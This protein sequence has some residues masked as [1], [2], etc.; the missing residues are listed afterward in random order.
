MITIPWDPDLV[1][2]SVRVSWHSLF[3]FI[4]LIVGSALSIRLSRYF[5]RD[6][7][8]YPFA[9]A[10]ILGGLASARIAHVIDNWSI[11]QGDYLKIVS[12]AGGGIG[13]MGAPIGS[14]VAGYV[15]A[16]VLRLPLGFMFDI[17]VVGIALGEAIGRIG[18][19][20]NGEHHGTP[21]AE[22]LGICVTY[23]SPATLGQST[24]VHFIGLYDS[25]LMLAT[26]VVLLAAWRKVR[27]RYPEGRIWAGYLILLGAGRF[28]ESFLR[29]DPVVAFGLQE[30]QILG[31]AYLV[32]GAVYLAWSSR[33]SVDALRPPEK[34]SNSR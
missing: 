33:Q 25:V 21:C 2:G 34:A 3:A 16:R 32:A 8:V 20:V 31:A 19:I 14:T 9:L 26:F 4:A 18:D 11:Y 1:I 13:T 27:G 5:V 23:T 28:L 22:P 30:G 10:V 12:F 17:T 24:P 6:Q 15:A 7:R 29:Q